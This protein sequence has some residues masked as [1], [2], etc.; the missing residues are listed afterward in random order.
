[1]KTPDTVM[2]L[3]SKILSMVI[4]HGLEESTQPDY[5]EIMRKWKTYIRDCVMWMTMPECT[6]Y[7]QSNEF[8]NNWF[9]KHNK[10]KQA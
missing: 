8:C 10:N 7:S 3:H 2:C 9:C 6:G 4:A 1:M 5:S